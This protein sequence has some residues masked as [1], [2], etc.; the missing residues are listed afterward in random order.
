[1]WLIVVGGK[2]TKICPFLECISPYTFLENT[3]GK[4]IMGKAIKE[5]ERNF[6]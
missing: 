2:C 1:M 6:R 3:K 4:I 5:K